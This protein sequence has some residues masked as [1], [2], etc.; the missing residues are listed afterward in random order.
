MPIGVDAFR[1]APVTSDIILMSLDARQADARTAAVAY[2]TNLTGSAGCDDTHR[3]YTFCRCY[4]FCRFRFYRFA[5]ENLSL[6][7]SRTCSTCRTSEF[8]YLLDMFS[9]VCRIT[10]PASPRV[11]PSINYD[12]AVDEHVGHAGRV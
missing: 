12:H 2:L 8:H 11:L 10:R 7:S 5:P 1:R 4:W 6:R 9:C 3:F